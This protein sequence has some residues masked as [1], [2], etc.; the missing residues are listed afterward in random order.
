MGETPGAGAPTRVAGQAY[1]RTPQQALNFTRLISVS[2][3][4][5]APLLTY[6]LWMMFSD[7]R[8]RGASPAA[9]EPTWLIMLA[10][11]LAGAVGSSFVARALGRSVSRRW[12]ASGLR[13]EDTGTNAY[14]TPTTLWERFSTTSIVGSAMPE[15][16][17]LTAFV[18]TF[19][20]YQWLVMM[21]ALIV[22]F[23][24]WGLNFPKRSQWDDW[25]SSA[26]L[27]LPWDDAEGS[28]SAPVRPPASPITPR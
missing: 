19:M 17:L 8:A 21:G 5:V 9:F 4:G 28:A 26:G 10:V 13:A 12:A 27:T 7:E 16:L 22:Y 18:V 14:A 6:V 25:A 11:G 23:I 1:M 3:T 15:L 2:L 24:F 20:T